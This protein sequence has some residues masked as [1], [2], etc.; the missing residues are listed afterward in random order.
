MAKQTLPNVTQYTK[1]VIKS[2][3]YASSGVAENLMPG[4][5]EFKETN[6]EV[7]KAA[8]VAI[9]D[10]KKTFQRIKD[11]I[12]KSKVYEAADKGLENI[13]SDLR[14]GMWYNKGRETEFDNQAMMSGDDFGLGDMTGGSGVVTF[15][16]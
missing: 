5:L 7:F 6:K 2:T 10:Y 3:L 16:G 1:N 8:Y 12:V 13:K 9:R 11:A 14:T 4:Y 15:E